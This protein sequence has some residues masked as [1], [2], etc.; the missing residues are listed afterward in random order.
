MQSTGISF[1][2]VP[3]PDN[4]E[5]C[6]ARN[7]PPDGFALRSADQKGKSLFNSEFCRAQVLAGAGVDIEDCF[8]ISADTVVTI[9]GRILGKPLDAE[10]A[11]LSL[12]ALNN[13]THTVITACSL[14]FEG[15]ERHFSVASKV[16]FANN[17]KELLLAYAATGE[18]LDKAGSYA[19]QGRGAAL[20]SSVEGS[21]T[22]I[23]GLPLTELMQ[24]LHTHGLV[25]I[26]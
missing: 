16:T 25:T 2:V 10:E 22:G 5:P 17:S 20:I 19:I 12:A 8:V 26:V 23:V 11:F 4:A 1:S 7:E 18:G 24:L 14:F 3:A 6:P 9:D 21:W 13:R 15:Q